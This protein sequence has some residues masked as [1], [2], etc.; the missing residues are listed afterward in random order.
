MI[1][2]LY[3]MNET[4]FTSNG[5]GRLFDCTRCEVTEEKNGNYLLELDY[6]V[7]GKYFKELS[8]VKIILATHD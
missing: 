8:T 2:I 7:S 6:P 4:N 5:V 3:E 1:P